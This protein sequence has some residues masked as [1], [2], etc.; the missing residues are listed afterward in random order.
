MATLGGIVAPID[1][2]AFG[3]VRVT[4]TPPLSA[5]YRPSL[6]LSCQDASVDPR[7]VSY[8]L[9]QPGREAPFI[10]F[11]FDIPIAIEKV[12]LISAVEKV[13]IVKAGT[14]DQNYLLRPRAAV[15]ELLFQ[16]S[17]TRDTVQKKVFFERGKAE[18]GFQ[19]PVPCRSVKLTLQED[20]VKGVRLLRLRSAEFIGRFLPQ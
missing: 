11:N 7:G 13:V 6:V 15:K 14:I 3:F 19:P 10:A 4:A 17:R 2:E 12:L 1:V 8:Y 18:V 20:G 5:T 16:A 9:S